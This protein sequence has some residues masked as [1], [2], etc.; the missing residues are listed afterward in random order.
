MVNEQGSR[1]RATC[2]S[3]LGEEY[4]V[5]RVAPV[6]AGLDDLGCFS[7]LKETPLA[8]QPYL[9]QRVGKLGSIAGD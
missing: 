8:I 4:G 7:L 1:L 3:A 5:P 6:P 2:P 9:V